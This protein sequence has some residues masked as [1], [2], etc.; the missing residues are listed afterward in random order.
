MCE[1]AFHTTATLAPKIPRPYPANQHVPDW[2]K[3][4]P[5][6]CENGG[7][8]KRCPPFLTAMG[9]G[10]I[11][12]VPFD[13]RLQISEANE[14]AELGRARIF[15]G[16]FAQQFAAAPFGG[17]LVLKFINPWIIVTPPG[18]VCLITAPINRFELPILA[19]A[20]I[21]ETSTYYRQVS[22]PVACL[23][24]PGQSC[25]LDR[26]MPLVQVIPFRRETWTSRTTFIDAALYEKQDEKFDVNPH[27]YKDEFWQKMHFL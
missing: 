10:Y 6:D 20:G 13:T 19:L 2:F 15:E 12:P 4:M 26:G 25:T 1:I 18:Y 16:H 11:I 14:F 17:C 23:L 9:A 8:L 3:N 5:A 7:T 24:R 21:V 22:L 27:A